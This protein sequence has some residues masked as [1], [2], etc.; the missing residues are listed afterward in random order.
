M[1]RN[2]VS[3]RLFSR[4][5]ILKTFPLIAAGGFV[6]GVVSGRLLGPAL[7]RYRQPPV[8]PEGSIFTPAKDREA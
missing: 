6:L 2:R 5:Q 1:D 4:R 8:F 3:K 7:R